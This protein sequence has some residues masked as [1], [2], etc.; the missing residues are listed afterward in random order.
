MRKLSEYG[1]PIVAVVLT[2]VIVATAA[3]TTYIVGKGHPGNPGDSPSP[4]AVRNRS[5]RD[6]RL[7]LVALREA[8]GPCTG[9]VLLPPGSR[10]SVAPGWHSSEFEGNREPTGHS[11]RWKHRQRVAEAGITQDNSKLVGR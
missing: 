5:V 7:G 8:E 11:R 6:I 2:L 3:T 10:E 9:Q 1:I 4:G